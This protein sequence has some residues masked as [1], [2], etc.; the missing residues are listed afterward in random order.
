MRTRFYVFITCFLL[1]LSCNT[2]IN[3]KVC[4]EL[5]ISENKRFLGT[6]TGDPFFW[7]GDTGWMLFT[8]LNREEAEEYLEDRRQKGFNVIQ[9]MVLHNV[10]KGVNVYGDSALINHDVSRPFITPGNAVDDH[11]QYDYWD[12]IDYLV[13]L[14]EKKGLYMALVPLWGSNVRNGSVTREKA[15]KYAAWL[16]GR[17]KGKSNVIWVNGGDIK[18]SDSTAIWNTIG[19]AIRQTSPGQ[20]ITF[21]PFG[22]TQSSKWFHNEKWLDFNMFQSGHRRYDQDTLD[23]AYGEDNWKYA[24]NDYGLTPIKPTM[25]GEPSYEGIPQ[26]LHDPTQPYW[27]DSDVRRY[28]YWSVFAGGCGFTYGNN[29]I[30]QFHKDGDP[31]SAYGVKDTWDVALSAPGGSQMRYLKQLMLSRSYFDRIPAQDL[32]AGNQGERYDYLAATKGRDYAFIYTCNGSTMNIN[33]EKMYSAGI[34]AS[35]YNP[36]NGQ[37]AKIG[38]FKAKGIKTFDPPDE[39][40]AGN[41]WVLILDC[42]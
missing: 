30:M 14:A 13:S 23:L 32:I 8:K 33:L 31:E 17:Y 37:F 20:L 5:R 41:D 38:T 29:A 7:L 25:D 11:E 34:E 4:P 21:H 42:I 18:G 26:G 2:G 15:E 19:S 1:C 3:T 40:A 28:A 22:R 27:T 36:R 35:W 6:E 10:R 24:V 9:V 12:H 16:A 39:K